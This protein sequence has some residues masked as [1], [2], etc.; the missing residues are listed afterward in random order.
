MLGGVVPEAGRVPASEPVAEAVELATPPALAELNEY[1]EDVDIRFDSLS[2]P[3]PRGLIAASGNVGCLLGSAIFPTV[4]FGV[5]KSST[6][7]PC[8]EPLKPSVQ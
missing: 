5:S 2:M 6:A 1:N 8:N 4:L 7:E 3:E